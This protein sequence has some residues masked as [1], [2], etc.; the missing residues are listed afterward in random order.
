MKNLPPADTLAAAEAFQ[1][2]VLILDELREGCPWDR[3][4]TLESLRHLSIEEVYE[5]SEAILSGD[6]SALRNELGDLLLHVVFYARIAREEEYFSL[7]E[8]IHALCEKLIRR[9]P[10]IYGEQQVES[11]E[12]VLQ[13]WEQIKLSEGAKSVLGG[14]PVSL[15]ALVKAFRIQEKVASLGFDWEATAHTLDKVQEEI[16]E[17]RIELADHRPGHTIPRDQL[18]AIEEEFGDVLFSLVNYARFVGINPE[19]ALERSNRKFISRFNYVEQAAR[20]SGKPLKEHTL[21]ELDIYWE[22]AKQQ[23]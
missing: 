4:Q 18:R 7:A 10:H 1:R 15:P 23:S 11:A 14:V 22:S 20:A 6:P 2:L 3:E 16:S 13:N 21:A 17:L 9:H 8:L 19:D 12:E 5:L